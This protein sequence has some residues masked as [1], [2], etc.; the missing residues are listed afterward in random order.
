MLKFKN[1]CS[2][3]ILILF[4]FGNSQAQ[5]KVFSVAEGSRA[6]AGKDFYYEKWS[7]SIGENKYEINT[8][9]SGKRIKKNNS[10]K[11]FRFS[12]DGAYFIEDV[13]FSEYK[14][15][16]LLVGALSFD[17]GSGGFILRLDGKTLKTKWRAHIPTF[18]ITPGLIENNAAY[19]T[20]TGFISKIN[21]ETGKYIWKH[22]DLYRKYN[23]SGAFERFLTPEIKDD[24]VIFKE[25]DRLNTGFDRQIQVNKL[26][27]KIIKV[28]LN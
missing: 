10:V 23:E 24:I 12:I 2:V 1:I 17:D 3:L 27:G 6:A 11:I 26:S 20:G 18:N 14:N 22:E 28:L 8:K 5:T 7:F 16:L 21:L 13:M 9:G 19:L 15:D 4:F 25:N